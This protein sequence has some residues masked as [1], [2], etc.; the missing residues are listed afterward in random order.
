MVDFLALDLNKFEN[1]MLI[2]IETYYNLLK[3]DKD[4]PL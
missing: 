2:F 1:Q 4:E 3:E